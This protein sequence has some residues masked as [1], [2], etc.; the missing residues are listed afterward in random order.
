MNECDERKKREQG[1]RE[2]NRGRERNRKRVMTGEKRGPKEVVRGREGLRV[3][4]RG[5]RGVV[6]VQGN[7]ISICQRK[8]RE[9]NK[10][11]EKEEH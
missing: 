4:K 8:K 5:S 10:Q 2:Q 11:K 3:K 9:R 1:M 7:E 6:R